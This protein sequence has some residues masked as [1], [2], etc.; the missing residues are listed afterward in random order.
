MP[1]Q[2]AHRC[3]CGELLESQ[4]PARGEESG[5]TVCDNTYRWSVDCGGPLWVLVDPR[6]T[7]ATRYRNERE[8]DYR[9]GR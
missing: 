2:Y 3:D 1:T 9:S 5:C 7:E 4:D 8:A 6:D